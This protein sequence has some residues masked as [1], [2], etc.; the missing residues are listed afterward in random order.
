ML[1]LIIDYREIALYEEI[2]LRFPQLNPKQEN[3][4]VGDIIFR[5]NS[6]GEDINGDTNSQKVELVIERKTYA[7]LAQSIKDGRYHEQKTRLIE[8]YQKLGTK[9]LYLIEE[10]RNYS[11]PWNTLESAIINSIIRD[12]IYVYTSKNVAASAIFLDKTYKKLNEFEN[13]P[14]PNSLVNYISSIKISKKDNIVPE[15][16]IIYQ[17]MT[18]PGVS[19]T[20]AAAIN[21]KYTNIYELCKHLEATNPIN[22]LIGLPI[23]D[24]LKIGKALAEKIK[25][26]L[27]NI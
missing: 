27:I 20:I 9:V 24:K 23:S 15:K 7:D 26:Y 1:E 12:S 2:L 18:I 13:L 10:S 21:T 25:K 16:G 5:N 14:N 17:L 8:C 11:L 4:A 3:L 6:G 22:P 19:S